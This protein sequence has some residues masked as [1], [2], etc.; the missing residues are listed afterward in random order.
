[1]Y[2]QDLPRDEFLSEAARHLLATADAL[3]CK[4]AEARTAACAARYGA[5]A[6]RV[7]LI[8]K[9]LVAEARDTLWEGVVR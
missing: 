6:A 8:V 3:D 2:V 5:R 9:R 1:M 4:S 7:R